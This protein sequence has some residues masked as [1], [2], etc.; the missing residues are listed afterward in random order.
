MSCLLQPHYDDND[1]HLTANDITRRMNGTGRILMN[2]RTSILSM[3]FMVISS[4]AYAN[5]GWTDYARVAELV[6]S[7]RHYY[8]VRLPV[9]ENPSGCKNKTWFY[10][11][12]DMP[13]SDK[14]YNTILESIKS[15]LRIRVYVTG[16]CNL[17]DY[18]EISSVSVIP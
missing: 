15:G 7:S 10:Q 13:G 17:N 14:M 6:A 12:Y 2:R 16:R 11:E 8:E 5:S 9:T 18:S 3:L 4:H 1:E